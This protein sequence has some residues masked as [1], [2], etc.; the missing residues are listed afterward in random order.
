MAEATLADTTY[1]YTARSAADRD[2]VITFTLIG[3]T[4]AIDWAA[5]LERAETLV[6]DPQDM[7]L[8]QTLTPA[9]KPVALRLAQQKVNRF[10]VQ[11]VAANLSCRHLRMTLWARV[12]GLRLAP[13]TFGF[14]R[15]DNPDAAQA[16]VDEIH[17]RQQAAENISAMPGPFDY[18]ITWIGLAV[19][20]N[21]LI[22][23]NSNRSQQNR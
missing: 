22:V 7:S 6:E 3:P 21:A 19:G 10:H 13:V 9:I 5:P 16:F 15:V 14:D 2:N 18:W 4:L 12:N 20:A 8:V 1:T 17:S 23:G 11:D